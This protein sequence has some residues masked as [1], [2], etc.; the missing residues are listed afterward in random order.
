MVNELQHKQYDMVE[1]MTP[2][3]DTHTDRRSMLKPGPGMCVV[4][5]MT[6]PDS[7]P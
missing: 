6:Q 7:D 4:L 5:F 2:A 1:K 3:S